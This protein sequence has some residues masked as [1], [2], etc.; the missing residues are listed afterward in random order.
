LIPPELDGYTRSRRT[1]R[2]GRANDLFGR[3]HESRQAARRG[4]QGPG[5]PRTT[6]CRVLT[7][8]LSRAYVHSVTSLWAASYRL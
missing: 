2:R 4:R 6:R 8:R 3:A 7:W 5:S 1:S